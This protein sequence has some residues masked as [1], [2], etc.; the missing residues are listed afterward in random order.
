MS[1][2]EQ[3]FENNFYLTQEFGDFC[4]DVAGIPLT[5]RTIFNQSVL[6]LKNKN[7]A[8]SDYDEKIRSAFQKEA[9]SYFSVLPERNQDHNPSFTEY[10]I[11]HKT[12]YDL[13]FKNYKTSFSHGLREG[14]KF[15]HQTKIIKNPCPDLLK[16]I[17]RIYREQ[18]KRKNSTFMPFSF[19][20]R[21]MECPS[22][23]LFILEYEKAVIAYA[24]CFQCKDNL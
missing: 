12:S 6:V 8:I 2:F 1:E 14:K 5:Q 7:I 13:A 17:Y 15:S 21:Y 20:E 16:E 11:F 10:S 22:A 19:F 9:I 3:A 18:I 23:L 24:F 4:S